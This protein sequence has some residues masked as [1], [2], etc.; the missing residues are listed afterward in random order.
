MSAEAVIDI[1]LKLHHK[2]LERKVARVPLGSNN[3]KY[4]TWYYGN[5]KVSGPKF[6]WCAV[7]QSWVNAMAG[8]PMDIY[9]KAAGVVQVRDF[10][11]QRGRIFQKP[12]VGDYVIFIF[13]ADEHHIGFVEKLESGGTFSSLEGNVTDRVVRTHHREDD[14]GIVGYARPEYDKLEVD[15]TKDELVDVLRA[16]FTP[17]PKIKTVSQWAGQLNEVKEDVEALKKDV[18]EILKLVK[19]IHP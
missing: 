14:R 11:K 1:L 2:E 3:V 19:Q 13:N 15:M 12:K 18:D 6:M 7:S 5:K 8:V 10:F 9:P 16:G 4:N 17:G